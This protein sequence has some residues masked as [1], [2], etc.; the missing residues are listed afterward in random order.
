MTAR[1]RDTADCDCRRCMSALHACDGYNP[2]LAKP[3]YRRSPK[4][5]EPDHDRSPHDRS[6]QD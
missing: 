4:P 2:Y 6:P 5:K 1:H 3:V